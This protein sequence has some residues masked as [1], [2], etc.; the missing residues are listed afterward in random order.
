MKEE[1]IQ[2]IIGGLLHDMGKVVYRQG[3]GRKHSISGFDFLQNELHIDNL[4]ILESVKYHH[5]AELRKAQIRNNS[6]A[7][8]TCIADNIA[9]AADR[10]KN[11][12]EEKGFQA[13]VPLESVFNIL[14]NNNEKM[15]Y[16]RGVLAQGE[17]NYPTKKEEKFDKSFY[18]VIKQNIQNSLLGIEWTEEYVNSLLEILEENLTYIPSSTAKDELAD[19]S[20]FDHV[21]LTAAVNSCIYDYLTEQDIKDYKTELLQNSDNFYKKKVFM[22]YSIDMSG[23]Q[24][25][26]YTIHSEGALK[27]L[28]AR[29]FYLEIMMEYIID[30]LLKKL[31]L[32]RTNLLY[33]GGGHCYI[34][35]PNT[36]Y[37]LEEIFQFEKELNQ[38]FTSHFDI[39]LYAAGGYAVCSANDLKNEPIGTYSEIFRAIGNMISEKKTRRYTAQQ[40]IFLNSH[41]TQDH[42]RECKICKRM[43]H[44]NKENECETCAT[45]AGMSK[46]ILYTDFFSI[47]KR[48]EGDAV[49]LPFGAYMTSDTKESLKNRMQNDTYY[50]CSY[51]KNKMYSGKYISTKLWVGNYTTGQTFEELAK[52]STGIKRVGILRADIDNLGHAF[53]SGFE[54][55]KNG[56]KYVSLSRT[57]TLSRQLSLFFKFY[58]NHILENPQ[59]T[60][61]GRIAEKRKATIVYSGGDDLFI[62][63][64]WHDIIELAVDIR[65]AF[66]RYTE[67]T[68]SL[69]AGI[70]LYPSGFP[71]HVSA[72][73]VAALE[74]ESKKLPDKNAVTLFSDGE[75]HQ[76]IDKGYDLCI[77]DGTYKWEIFI[78][79][80]IEEKYQIICQFFEYFEDRG[81][82]FLYHLLE[83]VRRQDD[84]I[85]LARYIY[86]LARM[87]PQSNASQEEKEQYK[88][89]SEKMYVWIKN[90]K[91]C[92]QLK[93]AITLYSYMIREEYI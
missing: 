16:H 9:S 17:I 32:S 44:L 20:L 83:L 2:L 49:P 64:A 29:S 12:E 51:G 93:T 70:G 72:S 34:L 41:K 85:N 62:V 69:S 54:S 47:S 4:H 14:N 21:K 66:T 35:L 37:V 92:R 27:M 3:D 65:E 24:N 73:E 19:I 84:K 26:I 57:T 50:I 11:G 68:L 71:I 30:T 61:D 7:Y 88:I 33:S 22:L 15:H 31:E 76:E 23:I 10:R 13:D 82:S 38:W 60:I 28:R 42:T 87:E 80:V 86:L 45:I 78:K 18:S 90:E 89:F 67:G 43:G 79:E 58:I 74:E 39:S 36:K 77:D 53:V 81:K 1:K 46:H 63:G 48:N 56:D 59:Y 5:A 25:F 75:T 91:D 52:Q 55:E 8:I 6:Y 40:I